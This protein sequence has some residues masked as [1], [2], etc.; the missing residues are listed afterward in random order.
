VFAED[1]DGIAGRTVIGACAQSP[2]HP[3]RIDDRDAC[4]IIEQLLNESLRG[5]SLARAG[6]AHDGDTVIECV[7]RKSARHYGY[8]NA[9]GRRRQRAISCGLAYHA[10]T[11][12]PPAGSSRNVVHVSFADL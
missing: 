11:A 12:Q 4:A 2:P 8:I 7:S 10:L 1:D 9:C 6:G 5:I 3:E